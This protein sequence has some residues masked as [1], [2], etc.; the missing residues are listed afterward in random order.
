MT[1]AYFVAPVYNLEIARTHDYR[2]RIDRVL[3]CDAHYAL[4][5][6][7][8]VGLPAQSL[9]QITTL[10]GFDKKKGARVPKAFAIVA[11]G[12]KTGDYAY[13]TRLVGNARFLLAS[14]FF[15]G[16]RHSFDA[17]GEPHN[18]IAALRTSFV[19]GQTLDDTSTLQERVDPG[20]VQIDSMWR[21]YTRPYF[22]PNLLKLINSP[23]VSI[24]KRWIAHIRQAATLAG[25][26]LFMTRIELAF[27]LVII[28]LELLLAS[29]KDTKKDTMADRLFSLFGWAFPDRKKLRDR[30]D[31][32]YTIRNQIVH[33]GQWDE[34]TVED[35]MQADEF[36]LNLLTVLCKGRPSFPSQESLFEFARKCDAR[37]VLGMAAW[38]GMRGVVH[39]QRRP[40]PER[41]RQMKA[42]YGLE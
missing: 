22:F 33:D 6:P 5:Y 15:S 9:K 35:L 13:E 7:K 19:L 42:F 41:V 8:R 25:Q 24:K 10:L 28:A 30:V 27:I 26:S 39:S 11:T 40:T 18:Q 12:K 32:L 38:K 14:S 17:F 16:E 34:L 29:Q 3:F 36:L 4:T 31:R 21:A 23:P 37:E 2:I 20:P 1:T